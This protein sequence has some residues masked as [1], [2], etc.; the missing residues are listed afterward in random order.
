ML[1]NSVCWA[2]ERDTPITIS[3][4]GAEQLITGHAF[5]KIQDQLSRPAVQTFFIDLD[6]S[7]ETKELLESLSNFERRGKNWAFPHSEI[8]KRKLSR[9]LR[10]NTRRVVESLRPDLTSLVESARKCAIQTL[11]LAATLR[12][13]RKM[14]TNAAERL[15]VLFKPVWV[16]G[17][18]PVVFSSELEQIVS[19]LETKHGA[20]RSFVIREFG[21]GQGDAEPKDFIDPSPILDILDE[22]AKAPKVEPPSTEVAGGFWQ[23]RFTPVSR[24][25]AYASLDERIEKERLAIQSAIEAARSFTEATG[26]EGDDLRENLGRSLK[27]LTEVIGLQRGGQHRRGILPLPNQ[28]FDKLWESKAIQNA[29]TRSSWSVAMEKAIGVSKDK[30]VLSLLAFDPTKLKECIAVL[31][32]VE[33][34]LEVVDRHIEDEEVYDGTKGDSRSELLG[35]LKQIE[36]MTALNSKEDSPTNEDPE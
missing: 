28:E 17:A 9:W 21:A 35:I 26:F 27:E 18:K 13:R 2:D 22:F 8:H 5:V 32:I 6:R 1:R 14:P 19:D 23:S 25:Q 4:T 10:N 33:R 24:M 20:I 29:D 3:K 12:D 15:D 7:T 34:F 11:A 16:A 36:E 30:D 31:C